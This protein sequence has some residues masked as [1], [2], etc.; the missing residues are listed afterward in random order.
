MLDADKTSSTTKPEYSLCITIL[1]RPNHGKILTHCVSIAE[2]RYLRSGC[3][4]V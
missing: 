3:F 1:E 4:D 2:R